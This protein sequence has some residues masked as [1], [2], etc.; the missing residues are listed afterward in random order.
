MANAF[1]S[2]FSSAFDVGVGVPW[3]LHHQMVVRRNL[4]DIVRWKRK[5]IFN[6]DVVKKLKRRKK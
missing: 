1:S 6:E 4:E 3:R 5:T 2:A